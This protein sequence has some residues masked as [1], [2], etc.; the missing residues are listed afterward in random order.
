MAH[1]DWKGPMADYKQ[2]IDEL[3]QAQKIFKTFQ[4]Q[5]VEEM[6]HLY[7]TR[8]KRLKDKI[9]KL[10][11]RPRLKHIFTGRYDFKRENVTQ[12]SQLISRYLQERPSTIDA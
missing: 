8:Q 10:R 3:C 12:L 4:E 11:K 7:L 5:N 2:H 9:A 1:C 6:R